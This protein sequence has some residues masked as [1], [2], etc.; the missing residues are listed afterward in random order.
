[1]SKSICEFARLQIQLSRFTN[2]FWERMDRVQLEGAYNI[3]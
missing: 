2:R 3:I 1:M